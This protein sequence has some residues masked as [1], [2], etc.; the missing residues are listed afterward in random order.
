MYNICVNT[1]AGSVE[2]NGSEQENAGPP[3]LAAHQL[4]KVTPLVEQEGSPNKEAS[5]AATAQKAG[6]SKGGVAASMTG[7]LKRKRG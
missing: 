2:T 4:L 6:P 3:A 5:A 1:C 7:A